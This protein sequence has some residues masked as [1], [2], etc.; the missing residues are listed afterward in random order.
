[1]VNE[2]LKIAEQVSK[3]KT[4][5]NLMH[6]VNKETLYQKHRQQQTRKASGVDG[7]TKAEY[8]SNISENL[9]GLVS[10]MKRFSYKPQPVRRTYMTQKTGFVVDADIKGFFGAPG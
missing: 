10:R 6:H 2:Y 9:D 3:F 5:Q 8:D 1:M 7:V 4:V